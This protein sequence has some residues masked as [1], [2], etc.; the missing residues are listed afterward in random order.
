MA[1]LEKYTRQQ[2]PHILKHDERARDKNGNYINFAN[3]S[4]DTSRTHLNYNLHERNDGLSDYEFIMKQGK[5]HLAKNV[6]NRDNVNWVGSWVIT[7]PEKLVESDQATQRRF[8]EEATAFLEKR[9]GY[10]NIVGAY[11]HNDETTPHMHVK[12]LPIFYDEKKKKMR[13]SAKDV[14]DKAELGIF[15][16]DLEQHMNKVFG[17]DIGIRKAWVNKDEK[18]SKR[19]IEELKKETAT[20]IK[21]AEKMAADNE[22][23]NKMNKSLEKEVLASKRELDSVKEDL[24]DSQKMNELLKEEMEGRDFLG[25]KKAVADEISSKMEAEIERRTKRRYEQNSDEL[26]QK[27]YRLKQK[28]KELSEREKA[29]NEAVRN[30]NSNFDMAD[31]IEKLEQRNMQL[32]RMLHVFARSVFKLSKKIFKE[33]LS[34]LA[35][36]GQRELLKIANIVRDEPGQRKEQSR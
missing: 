9:Y 26:K 33:A 21:E 31:R 13:M 16:A 30:Y 1:H 34:A 7:L 10:E 12:V 24:K 32:E 23:L 5:K 2:L 18:A 15:H 20:M 28:E 11:V 3:Q 27:S 8:F 14:F 25:R 19:T 29:V 4:I 36:V 17:Y 6:V 35:E 22:L